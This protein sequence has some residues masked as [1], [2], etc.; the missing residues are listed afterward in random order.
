MLLSIDS[1]NTQLNPLTFS[2]GYWSAVV[3]KLCYGL[4]IVLLKDRNREELNK[5]HINIAKRIIGLQLNVPAIVLLVNY[6]HRQRS[7]DLTNDGLTNG[8]CL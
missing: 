3:T 7:H 2:K 4:F 5:A 1:N 6:L 8:V